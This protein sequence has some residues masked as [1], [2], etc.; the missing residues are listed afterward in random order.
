M[1]SSPTNSTKKHSN[2]INKAT[3]YNRKANRLSK[4]IDKIAKRLY[5]K[6]KIERYS[7]SGSNYVNEYLKR[8]L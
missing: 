5:S 8:N 2:K 3:K 1:L 4:K 6:D 7:A